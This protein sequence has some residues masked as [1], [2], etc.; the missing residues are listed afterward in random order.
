MI[1]V[2]TTFWPTSVTHARRVWA[3]C[4]IFT[5]GLM[6]ALP[7]LHAAEMPLE[8]AS[9]A[10]ALASAML[11][12]AQTERAR[13]HLERA[14]ELC[15]DGLRLVPGHAGLRAELMLVNTQRT[16]EPTHATAPA[17]INPEL[18]LQALAADLH[19][20][21]IHAVQLADQ[22]QFD[23]AIELFVPIRAALAEAGETAALAAIE[24]DLAA[25]RAQS[26]LKKDNHLRADR[27]QAIAIAQATTSAQ[28]A[29]AHGVLQERIERIQAIR[30]RGHIELAL[31]QA[32]VLVRE[33]PGEPVAEVLFSD[34]IQ[35]THK[36]RCL[37]TE[38]SERELKQE[39]AERIHDEM[40]PEGFDGMPIYPHDWGERIRT[41]DASNRLA[42]A[43]PAWQEEITD[44]LAKRITLNVDQQSGI[45]VL[46][47]LARQAAITLVID[48]AILGGPEQLV[49]LK[50]SNMRLDHAL[51]WVT[52]SMNTGWSLSNGAVFIGPTAAVETVQRAFDITA[53][54]FQGRDQPG[55][56]VAFNSVSG[57]SGGGLTL[58]TA[59]PAAEKA[60]T[61]E[62]VVDLIKRTVSPKTWASDVNGISI[63]GN[64]LLVT[65]PSS[66]QAM[67]ETFIRA[68][69][70]AQNIMVKI[71]ARWLSISDGYLEEIGVDWS[72]NISLLRPIDGGVN[73]LARVNNSALGVARLANQLPSTAIAP[74]PATLGTGLNLSAALLGKTKLA[75]VFQALERK[76]KIRTLNAPSFTTLNG[77][78][79]N[80][81]SGN[82]IAYI[83]DYEIVT[84][85][86]DPK[87]SVLSIGVNL[88]IKPMVSADRKYVTMEFKPAIASAKFF[89]ELITA[90]RV[91]NP[92]GVNG[93]AVV[94][95]GTPYPIELP[96]VTVREAGTTVQMPD[97]SSILIGGF[98]D[99]VEQ[100]ARSGMPFL[101]N[102]P[103]LGRLF[104]KRGRYSDR[105][106]LYLLATATII[107][108]D[109]LEAL[110]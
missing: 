96:N 31:A 16:A 6:V 100:T 49:T 32:R 109:E 77:V 56:D 2:G 9:P 110:L 90:P 79:G 98:N 14:R 107:T 28:A 52:R 73:G 85:N 60:V 46:N 86:L 103:F 19:Q 93:G 83:S 92:G 42:T 12:E 36:Q 88:D 26:V 8:A 47:A 102:I 57:S 18:R 74:S 55:R 24:V 40:L 105:T 97:R 101:S 17:A 34:L 72:Q 61:P 20:A 53:L 106:K 104:G 108:Y 99:T 51:N 91:I 41:R 70:Q 5:L 63:R 35:K 66:V 4:A 29:S 48:A 67:L 21:R 84:G 30:D 10:D 64:L 81:F 45:D 62:E 13:T 3:C 87:I 65:A 7:G 50:A 94:V 59:A 38:S 37:D 39:V 27:T 44:R 80:V 22:G 76:E 33:Y 75:A 82:Q 78:R 71:D 23:A 54:T 95:I 1:R 43:V 89:T 15:E 25:L 58:F 69:E 11:V 68:Q